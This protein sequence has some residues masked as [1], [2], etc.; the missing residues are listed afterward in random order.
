MYSCQRSLPR[1]PV[2]NLHS[3]LEMLLESLKPL[4]SEEELAELQTEAEAFEKGLIGRRLQRI[5][6]LKGWWMPNYVTDWW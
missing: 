4:C 1:L 2:P 6:I 5:L 3:T